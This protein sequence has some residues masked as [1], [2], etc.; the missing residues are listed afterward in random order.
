MESFM[1]ERGVPGGA[2][3][4]V[5]KY[6]DW[7]TRGLRLG[8]SRKANP[9]DADFALPHRKHLQANSGGWSSETGR[10]RSTLARR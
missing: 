10:G 8:G 3:A 1:R 4:V 9:R 5:K 2:L 7:F 6:V